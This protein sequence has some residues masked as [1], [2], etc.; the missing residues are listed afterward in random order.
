L[1]EIKRWAKLHRVHPCSLRFVNL[2]GIGSNA[3]VSVSDSDESPG[4]CLSGDWSPAQG[5]LAVTQDF[6][7]I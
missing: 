4:G 6:F 7:V 2:T 1:I 3:T 5:N